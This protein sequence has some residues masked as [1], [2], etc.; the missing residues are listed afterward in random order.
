M[1]WNGTNTPG[2]LLQKRPTEIARAGIPTLRKKK[3]DTRK[4]MRVHFKKLP[5]YLKRVSEDRRQRKNGSNHIPRWRKG[6]SKTSPL[7]LLFTVFVIVWETGLQDE[8]LYSWYK[9][10]CWYK[11]GGSAW[12]GVL[13]QVTSG[14]PSN[15]N[16]P[17]IP[18]Q[19]L[20]NQI[21]S[22]IQSR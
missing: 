15:L 19:P 9:L 11:L 21:A 7:L 5:E 22:T 18:L 2:L 20:C 16:Q 6:R 3:S 1:T 17:A 13:H 8:K 10:C 4:E 14:G 12:A